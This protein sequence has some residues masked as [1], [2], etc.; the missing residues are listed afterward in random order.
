MVNRTKKAQPNLSLNDEANIKQVKALIVM[1]ECKRVY[2]TI[3]RN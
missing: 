1:T 3:Q 2:C